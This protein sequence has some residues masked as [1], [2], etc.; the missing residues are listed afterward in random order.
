MSSEPQDELARAGS[1]VKVLKGVEQALEDFDL[2]FGRSLEDSLRASLA[3]ELEELYKQLDEEIRLK[4]LIASDEEVWIA[5][6]SPYM[7]IPRYRFE[8]LR[9]STGKTPW[10]ER[11]YMRDRPAMKASNFRSMVKGLIEELKNET[12]TGSFSVSASELI[13]QRMS[14]R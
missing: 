4:E 10:E 13:R 5:Y 7:S 8:T 12:T 1:L 2:D 6:S 14:L 9:V 3:F 11:Y